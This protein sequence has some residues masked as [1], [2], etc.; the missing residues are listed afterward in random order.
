MPFIIYQ[1]PH[2]KNHVAFAFQPKN[3]PNDSFYFSFREHREFGFRLHKFEDDLRAAHM[4][5]ENPDEKTALKTSVKTIVIPLA[6]ETT[7]GEGLDDDAILDWWQ[8]KFHLGADICCGIAPCKTTLFSTFGMCLF[9]GPQN[10][11][12]THIFKVL[13]IAGAREYASLYSSFHFWDTPS[14]LMTY[15][16]NA[17]ENISHLL[18]TAEIKKLEQFDVTQP[19]VWDSTTNPPGGVSQQHITNKNSAKAIQNALH[20]HVARI[21]R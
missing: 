3:K 1:F 20:A 5:T 7:S 21:R 19:P 16:E 2:P 12:S 13:D 8:N 11:C 9:E 15:A 18:D 17:L 4:D 14:G 10:N 6:S